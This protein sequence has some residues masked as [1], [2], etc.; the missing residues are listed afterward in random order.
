MGGRWATLSGFLL[1]IYLDGLQEPYFLLM[2]AL[3]L[4][5]GSV[6]VVCMIQPRLGEGSDCLWPLWYNF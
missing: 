6:L 4:L 5:L 1:V 3:Q 2:P